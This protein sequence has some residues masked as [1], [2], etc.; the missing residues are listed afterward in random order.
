MPSASIQV[1]TLVKVSSIIAILFSGLIGA[2]LFIGSD[3]YQKAQAIEEFSREVSVYAF[4]LTSLTGDYLLYH[5][6]RAILQWR[7]VHESLNSLLLTIAGSADIETRESI[8]EL[9]QLHVRTGDMFELAINHASSAG[10]DHGNS[11]SRQIFEKQVASQIMSGT[12]AMVSAAALMSAQ[13][14]DAKKA[15]MQLAG[16]LMA[17]FGVSWMV[18]SVSLWIIFN[19]R[20][21]EPIQSLRADI[22]DFAKRRLIGQIRWKYNDEI[23]EVAKEFN[24]MGEA[25]R[26][27][28]V[29]KDELE[30]EVVERKRAE[31]AIR[32]LAMTDQLTGL[33]NRRQFQQYL[34]QSMKLAKRE[35]KSLALMLL[36]LDR[37]KAVNDSLGHP[38]GDAV[39][40][41]VSSILTRHSRDSDLV[42]RLGG[43][44]FA[45]LVIYP[46]NKEG[47]GL[48]AQRVVDE[49]S[50]PM[51]A[52]GHEI[53]VGIS[54]GI[55]F[56][57]ED[58]ETEE[59]LIKKAD[60]ALYASKAKGRGGFT[61][62]DHNTMKGK[63]SL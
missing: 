23:G 9:L 2:L 24:L 15:F 4:Q 46:E 20:I 14:I 34:V 55:A 36:D 45:R 3:K 30:H 38:A 11:G 39:L 5:E 22:R 18:F 31:E 43:D 60:L 49:V 54:I 16:F 13:S 61:I 35:G 42:A 25:L 50:K 47:A 59:A 19:R 51:D 28:L 1:R 7:E 6:N 56:Y 21:A 32:K 10:S 48:S 8:R 52:E 62:Y 63:D 57:P 41:N 17:F 12:H 44:E 33:A 26:Q 53:E 27:S 29:S 40:K 58:A 37:F